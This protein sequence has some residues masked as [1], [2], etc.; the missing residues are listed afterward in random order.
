[1]VSVIIPMYNSESTIEKTLMSVLDQDYKNIEII[2]I[3]DGSNDNS[4]ILV[5]NFMGIH[6]S[7]KFRLINQENSGV[8]KAR[9]KGIMEAKGEYI[10]FLDSDD[11]WES[12][13]IS[14]QVDIMNKNK[15]IFLLSTLLTNNKKKKSTGKCKDIGFNKL[16]FKNYFMTSTVV[17]RSEVFETMDYFNTEK[18]YS[19]DY[20]LWLRISKKFR[21]SIYMGKLTTYSEDN[22]GLSSNFL[23]MQ[24]GEYQNYK[25]LY[26]DKSINFYI[27]I[28]IVIF[29]NIK[30]LK[31]I[32]MKH[33]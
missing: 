28:L 22:K 12:N 9:N 21:T 1:M 10:A 24:L 27:F 29:S 7:Y 18:S 25:E 13:K 26:R 19:E 15:D 11:L 8:S 32:I 33:V 30:F 5:E 14:I 2:I 4:K 23:K 16:L 3:N 17:I 6:T 31:R 20:D